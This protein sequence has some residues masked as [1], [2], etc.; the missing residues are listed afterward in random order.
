MVTQALLVLLILTCLSLL[1]SSRLSSYIRIVALQGLLLG[2]L[3]LAVHATAL[4]SDIVLLALGSTFV[5]SLVVPRMLTR[6]IR[7]ADVRNATRPFLGYG[8]S[9]VAGMLL[10]PVALWLGWHLTLPHPVAGGL[11]VP[12]SLYAMFIGLF[13]IAG[14]QQALTQILGYLVLENGIYAFGVALL[15][16]YPLWVELA[17]LLDLLAAV[18]VMGVILFDINRDFDDLDTSRLSALKD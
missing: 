5:K 3:T 13:L 2:G 15:I 11:V 14:R 4:S 17:I 1:G 9:L 8:G 16:D 18:L 6:A 10:L 7:E 12:V